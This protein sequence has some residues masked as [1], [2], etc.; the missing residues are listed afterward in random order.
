[1]QV[2][3]GYPD[4]DHE[5]R[6]LDMVQNE[7]RSSASRTPPVDGLDRIGVDQLTEARTQVLNVHL[8]DPIK[9][10]IVRLV[11]A[12]RGDDSTL[13]DITAHIG[14][15]VSPRGTLALAHLA[16][17]R[18]W[19]L[20]RDHVLPEDVKGLAGD[21]LAHRVGLTYRAQAEGVDAHSLIRN[22]LDRVALT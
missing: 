6:I 2:L 3:V 8:S 17:A 15:P 7:R 14:H 9:N 12:T 10:Y 19:L 5:S 21:V 16:Q 4:T 1:M 13:A 20:Q 18:A 11:A 22:L